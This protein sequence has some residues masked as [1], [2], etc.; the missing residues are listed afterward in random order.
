MPDRLRR[1]WILILEAAWVLLVLLLAITS[2]P[3]VAQLARSENVAAPSGLPLLFLVA[4]FLV[5]YLLR[6]GRLPSLRIAQLRSARNVVFQVRARPSFPA[7]GAGNR[8]RGSRHGLQDHSRYDRRA[9]KIS[10]RNSPPIK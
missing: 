5:P 1:G 7:R 9:K 8:R 2:H 6:R 10:H 4:A 3:L